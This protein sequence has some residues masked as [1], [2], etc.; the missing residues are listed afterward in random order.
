MSEADTFMHAA[1]L[2]T[3]Q[4]TA[5]TNELGTVVLEQKKNAPKSVV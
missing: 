3:E 1:T 4:A 2:L 5:V